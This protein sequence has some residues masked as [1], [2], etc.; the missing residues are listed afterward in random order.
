MKLKILGIIAVLVS[1]GYAQSASEKPKQVV[2]AEDEAA[3]RTIILHWQQS[4]E[5]FDASVLQGDYAEDADWLNAFGVRIKGGGKIVEF[6]KT[7]VKRPAVQGRHTTWD[8]PTIRFLRSDVAL[9]TRDYRTIGHVALDGKEMPQRNTHST[10]LL[11]KE[12]G[13]WRIASQV[14]SDD[15]NAGAANPAR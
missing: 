8:E 9:A 6:V 15:N 14:I 13:R 1:L 11:T 3:V 4:W 10:W 7:V 5:N 12:G 2:S